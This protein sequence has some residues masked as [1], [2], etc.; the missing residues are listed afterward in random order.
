MKSLICEFLRTHSEA[1]Q[2]LAEKHISFNTHGPYAC[3]YYLQQADFSDPLVQECR[4][5]IVNMETLEV[6]CWPFRKF[7]NYEEAYAD[8]IDWSTARVQEKID[9]SIVK[10]WYDPVAED[11]RWSTN[12]V[13]DAAEAPATETKSFLDILRTPAQTQVNFGVL[14]KDYTYIFE[15]VSP[16]TR[17]VVPYNSAELYHLGTRNNRTGEELDVD[18]GTKKPKEYSLHTLDDVVKAVLAL[19]ASGSVTQEGFVVVDA[20]WHRIKVKSPA[21][22]AQAR[23]KELTKKQAVSLLRTQGLDAFNECPPES[24]AVLAWYLYQLETVK[25]DADAM[26]NLA[27]ALFNEY[28]GDRIAV[29]RDLIGHP[30]SKVGFKALDLPATP[31]REL[32]KYLNDKTILSLITDY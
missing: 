4:G 2:I 12:H 31:G 24:R 27:R 7:G 22:F 6:A 21:Y 32:L 8:D 28:E 18:I 1:E 9:G 26:A 16:E 10:L 15:L 5:I 13:I 3:F 30:L 23:M 20:N 25:A 17:V 19:N 14:C 29:A 11:W